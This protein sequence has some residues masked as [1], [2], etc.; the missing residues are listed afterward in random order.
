MEVR[1]RELERHLSFPQMLPISIFIEATLKEVKGGILGGRVLAVEAAGKE[2]TVMLHCYPEFYFHSFLPPQCFLG[3]Y[4]CP[5]KYREKIRPSD[6]FFDVGQLHSSISQMGFLI[7]L[8]NS[9][10]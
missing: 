3:F 10:V 1:R 4:H 2:E 5:N 7:L 9:P 6:S 8:T